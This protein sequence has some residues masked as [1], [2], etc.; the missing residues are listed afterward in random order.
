VGRFHTSTDF[1]DLEDN[2]SHISNP[3]S[4]LRFHLWCFGFSRLLPSRDNKK[5]TGPSQYVVA[6][7][8]NGANVLFRGLRTVFVAMRCLFISVVVLVVCLLWQ[9]ANA[10]VACPRRHLPFV[11]P[12]Q[13]W[14][15]SS[16]SSSSSNRNNDDDS[17]T[18]SKIEADRLK[19]KADEL[20]QQIRQMEEQLLE[21]RK[22]RSPTPPPREEIQPESK[23]PSLR[24]KR[25][26]V[27][28]ANGRLGSQVCRYL[29]RTHPQTEVVAAVHY[30]GESSVRG[31]ARLSY[32]VGA[33]DGR[34]R[35][36]TAWSGDDAGATFTFDDE[37]MS[38]YNLRNLRV[39]ECEV[40]DPAQC[41]TVVEGC[42]AVVW[43]ATDFMGNQPR[44]V[45]SLDVALL[46]RAVS[47]P[48]KGRVE[49]EGLQNMLGALK[50]E[51]QKARFISST[52]SFGRGSVGDK[53]VDT[54]SD[55]PINF[56]L[57][58]MAPEAYMDYET[59]FG[60]F[61]G[62]KRQGEKM[63]QS[64]FP[65]LS[66]TVLQMYRFDDNFVP[67]DLDLRYEDETA[68]SADKK[69]KRR[70]NR[71]D[72]ARCVVDALINDELAGRTVQV[73]TDPKS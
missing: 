30:V 23:G 20:R 55:E 58:S 39:V 21:Q 51:K 59:P 57:V 36:G 65:S 19:R 40:L 2:H 42:D 4:I 69:E 56:V 13:Q 16:S 15:S 6:N 64:D 68:D 60:S 5:K 53:R 43:C 73:W 63:V 11:R 29:L 47:R 62:I 27:V 54:T 61:L 35:L 49:V 8:E 7:H 33:E 24:N 25:V 66:H 46:F 50:L 38:G 18:A 9:E 48:D 1:F 26:L 52:S 32:E 12:N 41:Q 10:F 22:L 28:G 70:I 45:A 67:E 44:A 14:L 37:V 3:K 34:G 71:R 72:A 31:Y 17:N